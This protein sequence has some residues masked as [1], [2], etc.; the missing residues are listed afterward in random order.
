MRPQ[1]SIVIPL[2]NQVDA[3]LDQAVR[4]ALTQPVECDVVVVTSPKTCASN[5]EVLRR[6]TAAH[7]RLR[8]VEREPQMRFAAALNL[9]IRSAEA[10]R[11]AFLLTD[12]WLSPDAIEKCLEHE[13]DIVSTGR[14][15]YAADGQTVLTELTRVHTAAAYEA[16]KTFPDRA[17]FLGHLLMFQ[18]DR[19]AEVGGVDETLGDSPGVDDFDLIWCLLERGATV[20]IVEEPLYHYRDHEGDRLTTR[21]RE[22]MLA[23]FNRILDKHAVGGDQREEMLRRH[24]R[25]FGK[26]MSAVIRESNSEKKRL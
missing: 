22:D 21:K 15:F 2:L 4:S 26:S 16:L 12:D 5:R 17:K 7:P 8:V 11:I 19:L 13:T 20:A 14:I 25:W 24:S 10:D 6:I 3:W 18:R 23:T 9:G 1:A